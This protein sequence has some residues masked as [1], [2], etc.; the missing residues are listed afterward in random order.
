[1]QK[2]VTLVAGRL[3]FGSLLFSSQLFAA[4]AHADSL[5][6]LETECHKQLN[7]GDTGCQCIAARADDLLNENQ[8]A[9]VAAM[10]TKD[11]A[12]AN[13]LQGQM[14][15]DEQSGA[16]EFMMTAPQVCAGQ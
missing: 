4:T 3:L 5:E 13:S 12:A 6:T 8:Q 15:A 14:T 1:M 10:V 11:Q 16:A 7:L 9:L 2:T